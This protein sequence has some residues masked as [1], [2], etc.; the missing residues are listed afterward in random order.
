MSEAEGWA[1][2]PTRTALKAR[3]RN[4]SDGDDGGDTIVYNP[5][6]HHAPLVLILVGLPG[7]GKSH[8]AT[9]L[10]RSAPNKFVRINQDTL[11]TRKKCER[12]A[13]KTLSE[14]K[15]AVIDRCNF[16]SDQRRT[17]RAIA[18]QSG[19]QCDCVVFEYTADTCI[20]R[21]KQ[22]RGHQTLHP[23]KAAAVVKQMAK[24]FR[25]PVPRVRNGGVVEC[26]G[27]ERFRRLEQINSFAVS[28]LTVG[29]YLAA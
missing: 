7:S 13:Q 11:G 5:P 6:S 15:V 1:T 23:S 20:S 16:D 12:L 22:R 8:F 24:Q 3:K 4:D 27:G 17:W 19:V 25:P 21:C 2:V 9:R 26:Y 14:G 10:E 18:E 29:G 28:E